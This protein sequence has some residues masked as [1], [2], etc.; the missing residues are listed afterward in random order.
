MQ[1]Q[2]PRAGTRRRVARRGRGRSRRRRGARRARSA[3]ASARPAPDR[4][5]PAGRRDAARPRRRSARCSANRRESSG[6]SGAVAG[7]FPCAVGAAHAATAG[8]LEARP[9]SSSARSTAA[10]RLP[11]SASRAFVASAAR[12]SAVPWSTD[13]RMNGNP[14]VTLMPW[15]KLAAFSTGSP[16][17]WYIATIA[18]KRRAI[19]GTN[20]VSAGKRTGHVVAGGAQ[21]GDRRRDD[22]DLLAAEVPALAGVRVQAADGD[23][24]R[25]RARTSRRARRRRCASVASTFCRVMAAGTSF[26]AQV[27]RDER[28]AQRRVR[29]AADEQHHDVRR[30]R[31]LREEFGMPDERNAGVHQHALLDRRRDQRGERAGGARVAPRAAASRARCARWRARAVRA[32]PGPWSAGARFRLRRRRTRRDATRDRSRR[33]E[34]RGRSAPRAPSADHGRR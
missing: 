16:W 25:R 34:A 3:A 2:L 19:P 1:R 20:T 6:Q 8:T 9:A 31:A 26:S 30:V 17:S 22:V 32:S 21:R 28:D 5:R 13:V 12:S 11:G 24:R 33:I 29:R 18:S 14:S 15:P 10:T 27:G 23:A 4:S 7:A